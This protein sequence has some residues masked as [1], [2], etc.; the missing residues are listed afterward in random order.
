MRRSLRRLALAAL[1]C[2]VLALGVSQS[3]QTAQRPSPAQVA[4]PGGGGSTDG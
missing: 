2:L 1:L 3:Q 4:D